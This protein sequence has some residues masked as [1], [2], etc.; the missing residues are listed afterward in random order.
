VKR[1]FLASC[2]ALTMLMPLSFCAAADDNPP[3]QGP[4]MEENLQ[5][6]QPPEYW[7]GIQ[8]RPIFPEMRSQ[9]HLPEEQGVIIQEVMPDSPAAKA[10]LQQFD[11]ILKADD[12]VI[13]EI[14]DLLQAVA[15]AKDK[16]M[17]LSIVRKGETK[18]LAVTP[19]KRPDDLRV[20]GP[21]PASD[22]EAFRQWM[23]QMQPGGAAGRNVPFQFRIF[24]RPGVILPPGAPLHPPLPG[25]MS[26]MISKT[27]DKPAQIAVK[28]DDEKWEVTEKDLDKLPE[29]VRPHVEHMLGLTT[30]IGGVGQGGMPMRPEL[31]PPA[32][33]PGQPMPPGPLVAPE[34]RFGQGNPPPW[35]IIERRLQK[36]LDEMNRRIEKLQKEL[37]Q[38]I[39][40]DAAPQLPEILEK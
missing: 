13:S 19:V 28:L 7:L 18:T 16:E 24:G 6:V 40:S 31:V 25:N 27:G 12:K 8:L 33:P 2:V 14:P 23:E 21:P 17:K 37:H 39:Q 22:F 29:K 30:G 26:I 1:T 10:G 34:P 5:P 38:N 4:S 35:D 36:R 20:P 3:E 9:L 32:S 11:V 15:A